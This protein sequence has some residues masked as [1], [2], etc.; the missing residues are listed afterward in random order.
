LWELDPAALGRYKAEA[1]YE[2]NP[3]ILRL[4]RL[5]YSLAETAVYALQF[6]QPHVEDANMAESWKNFLDFLP[7]RDRWPELLQPPVP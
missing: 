7:T 4:Y 2:P 6:R 5:R 1:G 3:A